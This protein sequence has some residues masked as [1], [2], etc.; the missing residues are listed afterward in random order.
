MGD[1]PAGGRQDPD[2]GRRKRPQGQRGG[3]SLPGAPGFRRHPAG[4][5]DLIG[6]VVRQAYI[7]NRKGAKDSRVGCGE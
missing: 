5:R 7:L 4:I 6:P 3:R 2:Q 1:Q